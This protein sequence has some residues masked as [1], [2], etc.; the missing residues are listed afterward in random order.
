MIENE[1][2]RPVFL[3]AHWNYLINLTYSVDEK[4]LIPYL[5][6]GLELDYYNGSAHVSLVAFDFNHTRVKGMMIP[7]HVNF[8]EINLRFYV[9]YKGKTGVVFIKE[10]VPRFWIALTARAVY[11][12]PYSAVSMASEVRHTEMS[13]EVHHKFQDSM[14]H[15]HASRSMYTPGPESAEHHFK[16]HDLGFGK[17]KKGK[18]LAY[19]VEHPVWKI[20]RNPRYRM[21]VD[22]ESLYGKQWAFLKERKP[23]YSLLALGSAI[24]VRSAFLI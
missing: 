13:V 7:W 23:D 6:E 18:T 19:R 3:T 2:I 14:L 20:F 4:L 1:P 5:P 15:M 8:P 12:E 11:N 22:F 21:D 17:T 9:N 10:L 16:E 24:K